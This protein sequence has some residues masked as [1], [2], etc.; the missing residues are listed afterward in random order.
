VGRPSLYSDALAEDIC[1]KLAEGNSLRSICA[2]E[3]MPAFQTVLKWRNDMPSFAEQY[4]R[5]REDQAHA[6][7]EMALD[8]AAAAKDAALGRLA[9]DARKW[10]ASKM[11]PK[12]YGDRMQVDAHVTRS[13]D[14][15]TD[16]ELAM[17]IAKLQKSE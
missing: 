10:Y 7:A 16:D 17:H 12:V 1:T 13:A 6:L 5:A 15:M 2:E 14:A 11:A 8:E 4:A 9:Y 3:G